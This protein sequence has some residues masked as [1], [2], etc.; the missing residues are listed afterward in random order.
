MRCSPSLLAG[1]CACLATSACREVPPAPEELDEL[2]AYLFRNF[3]TDEYGVLEGGL[4]NLA[5]YVE[6]VDLEAG[7]ADRAYSLSPLTEDDVVDVEHP[8]RDLELLL[9]V[10]LVAESPHTP[11]AHAWGI[12]QADQTAA[13]PASPNQYTREFTDPTDPAGFPD[14]EHPLQR[15]VND[16][17]K[18]NL[19]M[20]VRYD[21]PKDFRWVELREPGS[22]EWA[23]LG[24]A[25][26]PEATEGSSGA[27]MLQQSFSLD[28]FLPWEGDHTVRLMNLW[29]ETE[30]DGVGNDVIEA[31]IKLG[32]H[33]MFNA[34]DDFVGSS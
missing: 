17:H 2:T 18:E 23:I 26:V 12:T 8:D 29:S 6:G 14:R 34:T 27:V 10:G 9:P 22:G 33:Q 16:I 3:E 20:D 4:G 25:W 7:Y 13:E 19:V 21:M 5:E 1:V 31:T 24:R 15:T 30:I 32:I 11:E 28:V